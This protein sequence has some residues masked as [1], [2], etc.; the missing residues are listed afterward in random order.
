MTGNQ[1][2]PSS[3]SGTK[4]DKRIDEIDFWRGLA[5]II[6]FI[7][8]FQG[9]IVSFVTPKNYGFSDS[10]EAFIF[11]SGDSTSLAYKKYFSMSDYKNGCVRIF[12]Q[13]SKIYTS[14]IILTIIAILFY[15]AI[16]RT[17]RITEILDV[18]GRGSI[19]TNPVETVIGIF[20]LTHQ[21]GYFNILPLYVLFLLISPVLFILG[22]CNRWLMVSVSVSIYISARFF[23]I[24]LPL[25]PET[26]TWY[27]NPFA[28]QLLYTL[29]VY[30]GLRIGQSRLY[31]SDHL[32][33][34][35]LLFTLI[36]AIL[37]SSAFGTIPGL[38]DLIGQ[39]VDWDKSQLG[40]IRIVDFLALACVIYYSRISDKFKQM[41]L[42]QSAKIVGRN[43]LMIY[44]I[45]SLLSA[46]GTII[47]E[48]YS[49]TC[50]FDILYVAFGMKILHSCALISEKRKSYYRDNMI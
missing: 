19:V 23:N 10:A 27:F 8:H 21:L 36:A 13:V 48:A 22:T 14:H 4:P 6:I 30:F 43:G 3:N 40:I 11:L 42:Y 32:Y 25:W 34:I 49:L 44:A 5:L 28:W 17:I 2:L 46:G 9:N 1:I 24:N 45:G 12:R 26:G 50:I 38:V 31:I 37:V 20:G 35:A 39:A 47:K 16:S 33:K 29:G 15:L 41:K 7:N 18:E